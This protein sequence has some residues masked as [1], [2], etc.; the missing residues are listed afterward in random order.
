M[1]IFKDGDG[2]MNND[3]R[4]VIWSATWAL[5]G[6][7]VV[8]TGCMQGQRLSQSAA[9]FLHES[10]CRSR[11]EV[12]EAPWAELQDILDAERG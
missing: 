2:E 9:P 4:M 7:I 12:G 10:A 8:C 1:P 6:G 5:V 11:D 3:Q